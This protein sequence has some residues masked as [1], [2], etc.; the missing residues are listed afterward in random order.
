MTI[1]KLV[2]LCG[3]LS[4][5]VACGG[6]GSSAAPT[7]TPTP[8]SGLNVSPASAA[9]ALGATQ[10]LTAT[11]STGGVVNVTWSQNPAI[12][13]LQPNG[14]TVMFVAPSSF[15]SPN[16]VTVTATSQADST[17]SAS[18]V[19]TVVFPND[20][21]QGEAAPIRLGTSGGNSTD[22]TTSGN[23]TTCCSGTLGTLVTRGGSFFIL[24]ANHVLDKSDHGAPGDP[25]GQPGLIDNNCNPGMLVANLTQAATLKPASGTN[26]P[27]PSNVDAAIAQIV[28]GKVDTSGAILDLG[29]AS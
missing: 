16:K 10:S 29:A 21:H 12:G 1:L 22:S 20:N 18:A 15:P 2:C 6:G 27:A 17:K 3:L 7:P 23:T 25:I 28:A 13:T 9:V 24:S 11:S 8:S 4:L 14:N 19:L 5:L 26:G